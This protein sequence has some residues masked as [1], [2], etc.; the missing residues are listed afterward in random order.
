MLIAPM[1]MEPH[2]FSR[3]EADEWVAAVPCAEVADILCHRLLRHTPYALPLALELAS[4]SESTTRYTGLRLMCNIAHL[5]PNEARMAG[6]REPRRRQSCHKAACHS[7][8]RVLNVKVLG[9]R[10]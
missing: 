3:E 10:N 4:A 6:E 7:A 8:H 1:L 2:T 5:H 9:V